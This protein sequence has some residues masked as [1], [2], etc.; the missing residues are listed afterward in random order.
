MIDKQDFWEN[1]MQEEFPE[2]RERYHVSA[3]LFFE[4]VYYLRSYLFIQSEE[5]LEKLATAE[6]I[7]PLS[8]GLYIL[9]KGN[10]TQ[11]QSVTQYIQN[12][13]ACIAF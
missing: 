10:S 2:N 4:H 6:G 8:K 13:N 7:S 11:R 3:N 5:E 12:N 1:L 9:K